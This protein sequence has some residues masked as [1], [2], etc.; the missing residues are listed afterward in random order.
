MGTSQSIIKEANTFGVF[1]K[2]VL[3]SVDVSLIKLSHAML[4]HSRLLPQDLDHDSHLVPNCRTTC[5]QTFALSI[6]CL[7]HVAAT[8]A[9][10]ECRP[11][12]RGSRVI[13]LP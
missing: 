13:G 5:L 4:V 3:L 10:S 6:R 12:T 2:C 8:S 1:P 9:G 11:L 7:L